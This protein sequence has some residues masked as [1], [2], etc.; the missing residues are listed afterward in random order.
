MNSGWNQL[1]LEQDLYN[2]EMGEDMERGLS[3]KCVAP[4]QQQVLGGSSS[5]PPGFEINQA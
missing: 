4:V 3:R 1:K 2:K 5:L